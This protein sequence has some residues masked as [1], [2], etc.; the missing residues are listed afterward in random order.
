MEKQKEDFTNSTNK[1]NKSEI[2]E[3][4]KFSIISDPIFGTKFIYDQDYSRFKECKWAKREVLEYNCDNPNIKSWEINYCNKCKYFKS[5]NEEIYLKLSN[6][7]IVKKNI[8]SIFLLTILFL[9]CFYFY[10]HNI[11]LPNY[12]IFKKFLGVSF[13]TLGILL[14]S[15][16]VM[17]FI[18]RILKKESSKLKENIKNSMIF[19]IILYKKDEI[20]AIVYVCVIILIAVPVC[21]FF[22]FAEHRPEVILDLIYEYKILKYFL[23]IFAL[24]IIGVIVFII[25]I[26]I[27][28]PKLTDFFERIIY[29]VV[30][31]PRSFFWLTLIIIKKIMIV[32]KNKIKAEVLGV[33]CAI[34]GCILLTF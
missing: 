8:I 2:S 6:N 24:P 9:T 28:Q 4:E 31:I 33:I 1:N 20:S 3:N 34:I 30:F 10:L 25:I 26:G 17:I 32:F 16:R 29:G 21:L 11:G 23:F 12:L 14:S 15:Y 27:I 22:I 7:N 13:T 18:R 19:E 5:K